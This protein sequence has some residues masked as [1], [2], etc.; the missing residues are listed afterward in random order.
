MQSFDPRWCDS[1]QITCRS[2]CCEL[3]WKLIWRKRTAWGVEG[4]A[5]V[6]DNSVMES[7]FLSKYGMGM[8]T[9]QSDHH[10]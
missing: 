9:K 4:N 3:F 2:V 6:T 10:M 5:S 7:T 8:C 1:I